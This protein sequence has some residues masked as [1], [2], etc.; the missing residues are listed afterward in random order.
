MFNLVLNTGIVPNDWCVGVILPLF[1]NKGSVNDVNNYRGITLLSVIGKLFTSAINHRLNKYL[2]NKSARGEEQVGFREGYSTLNHVFVLHSIIDFYLQKHKNKSRRLYCAFIDFSKAFD[3]L[4]RSTLWGKLLTEGI[5]GNIIRVIYNL[6][7]NAKS[8]VKKGQKLSDFFSCNVGVRQ[9]ENLSPLLF[10][11]YIND[12]EDHVKQHYGGL[13]FINSE[14]GRVA[15]DDMLDLYIRLFILLYADDTIILA[16]SVLELQSA[17]NSV[18]VYCDKNFLK[19]NL[20]KTKV[21][22]FSRGKIRKIPE[23]FYGNVM[24]RL[25]L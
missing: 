23:F 21:I 17:L 24:I 4:D 6:Y 18:K 19:V 11:M 25:M 12:F 8:C 22:V 3:L 7:D 16:E 5:E 13:N 2:E 15:S 20:T 14:L 1:K 9:G 10:A